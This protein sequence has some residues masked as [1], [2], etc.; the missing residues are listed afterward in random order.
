MSKEI[1][2]LTIQTMIPEKSIFYELFFIKLEIQAIFMASIQNIKVKGSGGGG[3]TFSQSS[4]NLE[5]TAA[6][7][8]CTLESHENM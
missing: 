1:C 5:D 7:R 6:F 3:H 4:V 8:K 2:K